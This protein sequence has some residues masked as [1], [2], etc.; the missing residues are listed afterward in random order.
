[1]KPEKEERN[2]GKKKCVT[3]MYVGKEVN[4]IMKF[5]ENPN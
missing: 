2:K 4:Y 1:M 5:M 3:F